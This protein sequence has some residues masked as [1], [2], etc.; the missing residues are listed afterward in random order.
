MPLMPPILRFTSRRQSLSCPHQAQSRLICRQ[1]SR[2]SSE[3]VYFEG[4]SGQVITLVGAPR[5]RTTANHFS[6]GALVRP[7]VIAEHHNLLAR[8]LIDVE[9]E[10]L[11]QGREA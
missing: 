11:E 1:A 7:N 9:T 6:A 2:I 5:I 10:V 8:T 3:I 4:K